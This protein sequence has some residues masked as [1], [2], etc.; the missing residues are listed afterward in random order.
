MAGARPNRRQTCAQTSL[1]QG[2]FEPKQKF[3]CGSEKASPMLGSPSRWAH[4][5]FVTTW[6]IIDFDEISH[7]CISLLNPVMLSVLVD[8][9][10]MRPGWMSELSDL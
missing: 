8:L 10:R 3:L 4:S 5:W 7:G 9:S 6:R 1:K 2:F